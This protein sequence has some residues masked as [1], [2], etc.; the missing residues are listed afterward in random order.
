[1]EDG[2]EHL[3]QQEEN[4]HVRIRAR[5]K[6]EAE[7]EVGQLYKEHQERLDEYEE[8]VFGRALGVT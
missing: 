8:P 5:H 1:V 2:Y 4:G 6:H 7:D 3:V